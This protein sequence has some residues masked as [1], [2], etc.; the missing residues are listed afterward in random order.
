MELSR[1][2][3]PNPWQNTLTGPCSVRATAPQVAQDASPYVDIQALDKGTSTN[4]GLTLRFKRESMT[5]LHYCTSQ[6]SEK[7][8]RSPSS[9]QT[10]TPSATLGS[11]L[12]ISPAWAA[13]AFATFE[14]GGQWVPMYESQLPKEWEYILTDSEAKVVFVA[15]NRIKDE[16]KGLRLPN[17]TRVISL[18]ERLKVA[19][20]YT[21]AVSPA[22]PDDV[23]TLIY[24][25]GT[26]GTEN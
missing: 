2:C 19:P 13:G 23:A 15:S 1:K 12:H 6:A 7:M 18:E 25:S 22:N 24:T 8:T 5:I 14:L 21:G 4:G 10:G 26:T 11:H 16:V 3:D 20:R 9:R 17:I